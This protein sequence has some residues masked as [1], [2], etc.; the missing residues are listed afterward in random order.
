MIAFAVF[1]GF[2]SS[3]KTYATRRQLSYA[4]WI[5]SG[6]V[7]FSFLIPRV[8]RRNREETD[9]TTSTISLQGL[10]YRVPEHSF[11]LTSPTSRWDPGAPIPD[12]NRS[13]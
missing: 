9:K 13:E 4:K 8:L 11:V 1:F 10:R 7:S 12:P 5:P 3:F 6:V 2:V